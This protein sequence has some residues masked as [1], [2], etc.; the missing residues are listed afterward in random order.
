MGRT[1]APEAFAAE[2]GARVR[3]RRTQLGWTQEQLAEGVGLH[4]TYVGSV[5]RGERNISLKN[6]IRLASA[7]GVD[8]GSLVSGLRI[9]QA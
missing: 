5:E 3:A 9:D 7:L 6:I 8:P 4:F 2:F 1:S